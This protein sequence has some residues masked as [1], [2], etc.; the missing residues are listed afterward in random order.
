MDR[1]PVFDGALCCSGE[2]LLCGSMLVLFQLYS[3]SIK[4]RCALAQKYKEICSSTVLLLK[5]SWG[6]VPL[7]SEI[8]PHK[9]L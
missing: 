7:V 8:T 3:R 6:T 4:G 5:K 1:W 9:R 2:G